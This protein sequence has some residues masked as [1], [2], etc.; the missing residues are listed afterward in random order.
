MVDKARSHQSSDGPGGVGAVTWAY[1]P[2]QRCTVDFMPDEVLL[3]IVCG[4]W[5]FGEQLTGTGWRSGRE[6]AGQ[7]PYTKHCKV[8]M[9]VL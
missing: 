9:G 6:T 8:G 3:W 7:G 2:L 5:D 1:S 4:A